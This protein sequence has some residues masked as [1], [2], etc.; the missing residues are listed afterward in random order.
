MGPKT[1]LCVVVRFTWA[2]AYEI[3]VLLTPDWGFRCFYPYEKI[4]SHIP[5]TTT[6]GKDEKRTAARWRHIH[7]WCHC[8]VKMTSPCHMY[9]ASQHIQNFLEAFFMFFFQ[10]EMRYLVVSKK[11]NPLFVWGWD[12]KIRPSRSPFVITPQASCSQTVILGKDFFIP[13]SHSC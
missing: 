11:K 1:V 6:R 2:K 3:V 10:F 12:R 8:N 7:L 4:L 9:V 13:S 5:H